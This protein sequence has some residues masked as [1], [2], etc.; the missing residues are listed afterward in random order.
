MGVI[1]RLA[2]HARNVD[3]GAICQ[4]AKA[5]RKIDAAGH[6]SGRVRESAGLT[7]TAGSLIKRVAAA[8]EETTPTGV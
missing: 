1:E 8:P 5:R 3:G 4:E 6:K 2:E 7:G